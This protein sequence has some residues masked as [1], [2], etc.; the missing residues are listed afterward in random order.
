MPQEPARFRPKSYPPPEFPPRR[1]PRFARVPPAVFPP[2]LGAIGLV[3]ALR[4]GL[5]A[6]QLPPA[7]ADFLAG[8]VLALWAFAAFAYAA[9]LARRPGVLWEDLRVLPGR[10]GLASATAGALALAALLVPFSPGAA[11]VM[12][13]G[14]LVLHGALALAV[15]VALARMPAEARGVTPVWHLSFVGFIIGGLAAVPLGYP[16]LAQGLFWATLPVAAAIWGISLA[17]LARRV[18][19]AP[20]RPL[21]AI[22][23]AP[24][25]LF[26]LVAG[27]LGQG[28]LSAGFAVLGLVLLA[29]LLAAG[30]WVAESG[31]SPLW[32]AFTFPLA[33]LASAL[34][35]QDGVLLWAGIAVLAAAVGFVPYVLWQVLKLW[36]GG[37]LAAKTNAAEA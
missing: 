25:A 12:L 16:V 7:P 32:G 9:K 31:F 14:G 22:H 33:A 21:L 1:V 27:M 17:Q 5:A 18:P 24:A 36:P 35:A 29:A 26:A 2:I 28:R 23:I 13:I 8:L 34:L 20:L 3:L 4:R 37:R 10:A 30:R 15:L 19:P 11:R 6:L